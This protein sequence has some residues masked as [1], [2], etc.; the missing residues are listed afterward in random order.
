MC[1][2]LG[3]R[4]EV[5][6][7]SSALTARPTRGFKADY[8]FVTT[9]DDEIR[10]DPGRDVVGSTCCL[11]IDVLIL[12]TALLMEREARLSRKAWGRS[13]AASN[14]ARSEVMALHTTVLGQQSEIAPL[15]AVDRAR[16]AQLVE[17]LRLVITLQTQ[18]IALQGQ[19]GP[20]GG[21][22]QPE[23]PEEAGSSS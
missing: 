7:S 11:E 13:M 17:T 15:R 19:Q 6:E 12:D 21:S 23:I 10:R 16:Q 4:Y 14:A 18:V 9:L 1:I 2:A 3:L 8:G 22:A 20:V 5:G